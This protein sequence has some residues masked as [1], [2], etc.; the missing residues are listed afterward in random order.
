MKPYRIKAS[1][2]REHT[3]N[4]LGEWIAMAS[5]NKSPVLL[6]LNLIWA[7]LYYL[8][9]NI[10]E[11]IFDNY[12]IQFNP[13][14]RVKGNRNGWEYTYIRTQLQ[15]NSIGKWEPIEISLMSNA[16]SI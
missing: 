3:D 13:L 15:E 6:L 4:N 8:F 7:R 14:L 10:Q 9:G 2:F 1:S 5:T 11:N 16:L 12:N